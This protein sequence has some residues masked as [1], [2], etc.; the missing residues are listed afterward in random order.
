MN[1]PTVPTPK[2]ISLNVQDWIDFSKKL[3]E[4]IEAAKIYARNSEIIESYIPQISAVF[5]KHVSSRFSEKVF[6]RNYMKFYDYKS[7]M[8][9]DYEGDNVRMV[10]TI[11]NAKNHYSETIITIRIWVNVD[12]KCIM[13]NL[14]GILIPEEIHTQK[15][16]DENMAGKMAR[17]FNRYIIPIFP[18]KRFDRNFVYFHEKENDGKKEKGGKKKHLYSNGGVN[19]QYTFYKWN[20]KMIL[21]TDNNLN[22]ILVYKETII[23]Y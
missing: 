17:K 9:F 11:E 15:L 21:F 12:K 4:N 22:D 3:S 13:G 14:K 6:N 23:D 18:N 7:S 20:Q 16:L 5:A 2:E 10:Y 8:D 19:I 1:T